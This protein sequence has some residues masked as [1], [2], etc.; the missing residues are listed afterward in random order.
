MAKLTLYAHLINDI[1]AYITFDNFQR[2]TLYYRNDFNICTLK[3]D[4]PIL[5]FLSF[6]FLSNKMNIENFSQCQAKK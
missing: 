2:Q 6:F 4:D 5:Q 3:K 1:I